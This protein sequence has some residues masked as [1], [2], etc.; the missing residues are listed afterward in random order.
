MVKVEISLPGMQQM[1]NKVK[2]ALAT[3]GVLAVFGIGFFA[4][5]KTAYNVAQPNGLNFS[6]FWDAYNKLQ[7]NFY[8]PS[9]IKNSSVEYGAIEGMANS[10]GDP[11]TEFFDPTSAKLFQSDLAGSFEGIGAQIDIENGVLTVVAPIPGTP[12]AKAGLKTGDAILKIN[13]IDTSTLNVDEATD[14]IRGAK[15]T[16]VTLNIFRKGWTA[17]KD[18]TITRDTINAPVVTWSMK[19][20]DIAYLQLTQFDQTVPDDFQK[21]ANQILQSNAKGIVLDLR[22]DPGGY[23]EVAQ[24]VA[25]WFLQSGSTVTVEDFG[26]KKAQQTYKTSGGGQLEKYPLVILV[27]GGSA[28]ASEILSGALRDDRGIKLVGA[29]SFGKGSVQNILTFPDGSLLK[30][31]IAHWLTPKGTSINKVGLKP[32][33]AVTMPDSATTP[34]QDPQLQKALEMVAAML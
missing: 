11:Y 16:T 9:K 32:D 22:D 1:N 3:V 10:L 31:T 18:F 29:Q 4:G 21:A 34:T 27:N 19:D 15:G 17:A 7:Q 20:N 5:N 13:N 24:N 2:Y 26:G 28:S 12:A 33:V 6:E 30:V 25:G 23:L 8:D 14:D